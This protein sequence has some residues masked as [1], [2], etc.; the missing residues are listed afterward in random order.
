MGY[1][2][3]KKMKKNNFFKNKS[4]FTLIE[5]LVAV[6][7]FAIIVGVIT[8][9]FI[10]AIRSQKR[11]LAYQE[12]F[13]QISYVKE[14]MSRGLKMAVKEL[15]D[16][17]PGDLLPSSCLSEIGLNYQ[18]IDSTGIKFLTPIS[19]EEMLPGLLCESFYSSSTQIWHQIRERNIDLPLTPPYLKVNNLK[20]N[21]IG[22]MQPPDNQQP[23]VTFVIDIET[24]DGSKIKLQTTIS[25]RSFDVQQ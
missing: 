12:L 7:I 23:R 17:L 22:E 25:Q 3:F 2:K 16:L 1:K 13:D 6:S 9:S 8:T 4:G 18:L 15:G 5:I 20:F 21:L 14:Y 10:S 11:I 19:Q 24:K